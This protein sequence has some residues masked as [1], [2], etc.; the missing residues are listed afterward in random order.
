MS[1]LS[2]ETNPP[3]WLKR[4]WRWALAGVV[5]ATIFYVVPKLLISRADTL[6]DR[7]NETYRDGRDGID[8]VRRSRLYLQ[9]ARH[10]PG[11]ADRADKYLSDLVFHVGNG[12]AVFEHDALPPGEIAAGAIA[13]LRAHLTE[14][15]AYDRE[16]GADYLYGAGYHEILTEIAERDGVLY[17]PDATARAYLIRGQLEPAAALVGRMRRTPHFHHE[18][19]KEAPRLRCL[20]GDYAPALAYLDAL[21]AEPAR[22][23]KIDDDV[24][25]FYRE[26]DRTLFATECALRAGDSDRAQRGAE[27]LAAY[28]EVGA[29]LGRYVTARLYD[30]DGDRTAAIAAL[31]AV[32][33]EHATITRI[34]RIPMVYLVYLLAA[35]KRFTELAALTDDRRLRWWRVAPPDSFTIMYMFGDRFHDAPARWLAIGDALAAVPAEC[36]RRDAIER[37]REEAYVGAIVG[38]GAR[39]DSRYREVIAKLADR[40]VAAAWQSFI[41]ALWGDRAWSAEQLAWFGE[42]DH[43]WQWVM[44]PRAE[45]L[46]ALERLMAELPAARA[47][48]VLHHVLMK[49]SV[50]IAALFFAS[51]ARLKYGARLELFR[52]ELWREDLVRWRELVDQQ[53]NMVLLYGL[54]I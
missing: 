17:Y 43:G 50:S 20:V 28:Q 19:W 13:Y 15:D 40:E 1:E 9:I 46:P 7:A 12:M 21:L 38:Y 37:L 32:A 24:S 49:D 48:H 54:Q 51:I 27:R 36:P 14:S 35:E 34:E 33:L 16:S 39:R 23:T 10:F 5:A 52:L 6:G 31:G 25:G 44:Q 4:R 18:G 47:Q 45:N 11:W 26:L 30:D 29:L 8:L 53:P 2:D 3:S 41:E 22:A 42:I